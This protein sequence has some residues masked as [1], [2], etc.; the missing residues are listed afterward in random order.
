[1]LTL[2]GALALTAISIGIFYLDRQSG[3]PSRD[4]DRIFGQLLFSSVSLAVLLWLSLSIS[5]AADARVDGTRAG[6]RLVFGEVR[7]RLP[8]L[9]GWWAISVAGWIGLGLGANAVLGPPVAFLA[10]NLLWGIGTFFVV[11]ALAIE[12]GGTLSALAL[13]LRLLFASWGR[14]LV[15]LLMLICFYFVVSIPVVMLLRAGSDRYPLDHDS[16]LGLYF[17]GLALFYLTA[18]VT[19]AGREGFAVIRARDIL[20]DLPGEPRPRK[21]RQWARLRLGRV[22]LGAIG[23]VVLLFVLGA[24]LGWGKRGDST[25]ISLRQPITRFHPGQSRGAVGEQPPP[26]DATASRRTFES[27]PTGEWVATGHVLTASRVADRSVGEVLHRRWRFVTSCTGGP[28]RSYLLRT[29]STGVQGSPLHFRPHNYLAE[30]GNLQSTCEVRP[31]WFKSFSVTFS[32]WWTKHRSQLVAEEMGGFEGGPGCRY[33]GERIRW[34][35]H[36]RYGDASGSSE[37]VL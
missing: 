35:A 22:V 16:G 18:T 12:G 26:A 25:S 8:A 19:I 33:A 36:R 2:I 29:S 13:G 4:G 23:L 3:P 21:H 27:R 6:I 9:L 24:I 28:C 37:E 17:G 14:V 11:S 7:E 31:G 15:A 5:C 32:I 34:T 1:M 30:F 20:G 10:V